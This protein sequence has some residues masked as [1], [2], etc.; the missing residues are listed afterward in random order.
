MIHLSWTICQWMFGRWTFC[1]ERSVMI[2]LSTGTLEMSPSNALPRLASVTSTSPGSKD[3]EAAWWSTSVNISKRI[4][5]NIQVTSFEYVVI[6]L[7]TP[8]EPVTVVA[9]YHPGSAVPDANFFSEFTSIL[10]TLATLSGY[11]I[12]WIRSYLT[13][14]SSFVKID[15][16]SSPSTTILTGVP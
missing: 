2:P 13:D 3:E 8:G 5:I 10:E 12:S 9:I 1:H 4:D 11:A 14:R 16:S 7:T 15:S 6:S